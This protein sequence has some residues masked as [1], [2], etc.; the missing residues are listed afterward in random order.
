[1]RYR[2]DVFLRLLHDEERDWMTVV[3]VF[4]SA[5]SSRV[6]EHTSY[7]P[8]WAIQTRSM[9]QIICPTWYSGN[10]HQRNDTGS[11]FHVALG[12]LWTACHTVSFLACCHW[13]WGW[14]ITPI[15]LST[16]PSFHSPPFQPPPRDCSTTS[17]R[18]RSA[19]A[20]CSHSSTQLRTHD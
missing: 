8:L 15:T 14:Y 20:W 12:L 17:C 3:T 2:I 13:E 10:C 4:S 18:R 9:L 5:V 11:V 1:M 6:E 19:V 16:L 7:F